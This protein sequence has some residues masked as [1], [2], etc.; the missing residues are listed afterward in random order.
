MGADVLL[1]NIFKSD[2]DMAHTIMDSTFVVDFGIIKKIPAEGI[3]T[4]EMAVAKDKDNIIITNC[5]LANIAS[6]S[7]TI[8]MKPN[9]DDKVIVLFPR[10]FAGEMFNPDKNEA[11]LYAS[12]NG[13]SLMGGIAILL[14]QYQTAYHK[15]FVDFSDGCITIKMAYSEDDDKNLFTIETNAD[16]ELVL[17]SNEVEISTNKDNEITIKNSKATVTID[18][19]GNVKIESKGKYTIK[20]NSTDLKAVVDGLA[21][22]LENLTTVGSPATQATSPASKGTIATWRSSK[23][24]Q[25]FQ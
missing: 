20:N 15:N 14:N 25:L 3:V 8:N 18:K 5:V 19:D 7:T 16:G 22:E 12:S 13:Y 10:K 4:V 17:K 11:L 1:E 21:Q 24:N 23:L 6:S 2:S 9:I